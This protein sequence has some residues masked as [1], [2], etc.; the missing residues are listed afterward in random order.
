[1][2]CGRSW[3]EHEHMKP[4]TNEANRL[5]TLLAV[6]LALIFGNECGTP[7]QPQRHPERY[8]SVGNVLG[9]LGRVEGDK[10]HL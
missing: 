10:H 7:V 1:M 8:A 2:Q 3:R 5:E 9:V 4:F 6:A